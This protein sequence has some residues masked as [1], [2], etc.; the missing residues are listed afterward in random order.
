MRLVGLLILGIVF[1]SSS[2][3]EE[4]ADIK[5]VPD[6]INALIEEIKAEP[7]WN[8]PAKVYQYQF[9]G[10]TVYFVPQRCCDIPGTLYNESC[11]AICAPDGGLTGGGDG[12]CPNFF[13]DSTNEKLI[14]EDNRSE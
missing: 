6:C 11:Q 9:E 2:C 1:L 3:K 10:E 12:K 13:D 8:P 14:W 5:E 7:V 4:N